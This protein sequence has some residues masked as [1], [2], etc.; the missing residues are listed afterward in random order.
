MSGPEIV[1]HTV[2]S[3]ELRGLHY[4]HALSQSITGLQLHVQYIQSVFDNCSKYLQ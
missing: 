3:C 1:C 4:S 2:G